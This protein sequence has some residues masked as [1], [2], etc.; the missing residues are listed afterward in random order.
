MIFIDVT[1]LG[2]KKKQI[3]IEMWRTCADAL[4]PI[5]EQGG[6]Y[7]NR[8]MKSR[9]GTD[10]RAEIVIGKVVNR[11]WNCHGQKPTSREERE[12]DGAPE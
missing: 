9:Q 5:P 8:R 1:L 4:A 11:A 12:K 10:D 2:S 6:D 7:L 3:L